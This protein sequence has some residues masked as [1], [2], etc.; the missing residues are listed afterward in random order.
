MTGQTIEGVGILGAGR[1]SRDHAYA[2]NSADGLELIG[3]ADPEEERSRAFAEKYQCAGYTDPSELLGRD[4]VDLILVGVPHWLHAPVCLDALRAGK[5]VMVEKPMAMTVDE[6]QAMVRAAEENSVQ[7][8]VGHTQHFFPANVAVEKWVR[9]GKIGELV[10]ATQFWFK[11]F[12]LAGRPPWMLDRA[13]GGGMWLMNGAHM[14]DLLIWLVGSE[15]AAVKA[16]VTDKVVRQK[17][18]DSIIAFVEFA[19][20]VCAT[21][22]HSGSKR[23]DP[24]PPEQYMTTELVGTEGKLKVVSYEGQAWIDTDGEAVPLELDRDADRE[25]AVRQFLN[26]ENGKPADAPVP[27]SAVEQ[28]TGIATEVAAF[29]RAIAAGEE[30]PVS[31]QQSIAVIKAMLAIEESSRTGREVRLP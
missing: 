4:D 1:V 13:R 24:P 14:L 28:T 9:Q 26:A 17:A 27:Q 10:M 20:G 21:L 11:P 2:V 7:L 6:C 22:A 8:M 30:L 25:Q 3:V 19:N 12:G 5:H 29:A 15:V 18:D 16:S 31:N 23:P